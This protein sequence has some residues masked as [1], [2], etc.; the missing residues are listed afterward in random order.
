MKTTRLQSVLCLLICFAMFKGAF[1]GGNHL[2]MSLQNCSQPTSNSIQFDLYVVNDGDVNSDL[3]LNSIQCGLNF[4]A[5]AIQRGATITTS[6]VKNTTEFPELNG[7]NFPKASSSDHIRIVQSVYSKGNTG[8]SLIYGQQYKV[9]TFVISSSKDWTADVT[10]AI[11]FQNSVAAGKTVCAALTWVGGASSTIGAVAPNSVTADQQAITARI[12]NTSPVSLS[13]VISCKM[14]K[15][16]TFSSQSLSVYPNP[17]N[18]LATVNFNT[19][20]SDYYHLMLLDAASREV[21]V[22]DGKSVQ[23]INAFDLDLTSLA[24]GVYMLSIQ[25]GEKK[26]LQRVI[27]N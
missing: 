3:R 22:K 2:T 5:I 11:E 23:G 14:A 18:G 6:Y 24:K 9:G 21:M 12:S 13:T 1:A 19:D 8:K 25:Q 16:E 4:N 26:M 17:T 27:V 15:D 20:A 7:F 10:P